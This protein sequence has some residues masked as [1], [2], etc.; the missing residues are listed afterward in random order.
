MYAKNNALYN[1]NIT[2]SF[3]LVYEPASPVNIS[4]ISKSLERA[5]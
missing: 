2:N 4:L 1:K 3:C 5:A